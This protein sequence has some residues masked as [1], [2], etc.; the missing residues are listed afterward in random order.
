MDTRKLSDLTSIGKAMI[1]DFKTLRIDSVAQ[2]AAADPKELYDRL[3]ALSG[4][5]H[6]ICVLDTL[7]A[8]VAQAR[9]PDL[10]AEQRQWWYWSRLRKA[11][12]K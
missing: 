2:L 10:P 4:T 3:G 9:D 7:R 11:A 1:V 5:P 12:S 8:A 6:D